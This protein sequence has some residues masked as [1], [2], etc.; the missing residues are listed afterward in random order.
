MVRHPGLLLMVVLTVRMLAVAADDIGLVL[1]T[2]A[3]R[4][5]I[6]LVV[7]SADVEVAKYFQWSL[8]P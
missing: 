5:G 1:L 4:L 8:Q 6:P 3:G 2:I 7:V